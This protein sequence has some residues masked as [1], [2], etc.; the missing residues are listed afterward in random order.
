MKNVI[1]FLGLTGMLTSCTDKVM[2]QY[3][4]QTPIY[5]SYADLRKA[6]K[7][8]SSSNKQTDSLGKIYYWN[9]FLFVNSIGKGIFVIDDTDPAN[10]VNKTFINIPGNIDMSVKDGILYADSYIDLVMIDINDMNNI[11]EVNRLDSIFPYLLPIWE[12]TPVMIEPID[13]SKGVVVSYKNKVV[14]KD[15]YQPVYNSYGIYPNLLM[16]KSNSISTSSTTNLTNTS[17]GTGG[18]MARF[19]ICDNALYTINQSS[20]IF[21]FNIND[22]KKPVKQA[23][24][25]NLFG[26][27]TLFPYNGKLFIGSQTGMMIYDISNPFLPQ[28][29]INY[30]H[31]HSCDPV[32]VDD[33]FAYVTLHTG[34][35]CG[36]DVNQLEIINISNISNPVEVKAYDMTYPQGLGIDK[37]LLF[38]CDG[39]VG[40]RIFDVTD[41]LTVNQHMIAQY[42][43]YNAYDVIPLNGVLLMVSDKGLYQYDYSD[44]KNIKLLSKVL[45]QP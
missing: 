35:R 21:V 13:R 7:T 14:Q 10:P 16:D 37:N 1:I 43:E 20:E 29:I 2:E 27:E 25:N 31:I 9:H 6:V 26:I 19:T 8:E 28:F 3:T 40:L 42:P 24:I 4:V 39:K 30:S 22:G 44:V 36:G 12:N 17:T 5:M 23:E 18:S 38:I 11:R 45:S 15:M 33:S 32:V 34:T 41:K